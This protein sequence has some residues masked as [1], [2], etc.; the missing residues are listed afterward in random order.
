MSAF[1]SLLG[2]CWVYFALTLLIMP[3]VL[4]SETR[5]PPELIGLK[6]AIALAIGL[7][8]GLER[9]WSHK[10]TGVRTFA[11]VSLLGM[12]SSLIA[13]GFVLVAF[14]GVLLLVTFTN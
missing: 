10:E 1:I 11:I 2:C 4:L 5:F 14:G 8:A 7:L 12:A 13:P 6:I 9:E 3:H